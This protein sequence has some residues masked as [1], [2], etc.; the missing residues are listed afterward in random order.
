MPTPHAP[1]LVT[2]YVY[3]LKLK[4]V[5]TKTIREVGWDY[6][7]TDPT[8]QQELG[9]HHFQSEV[10]MAKGA[11]TTAVHSSPSPPTRVVTQSAL[12]KNARNPFTERILITC[13]RYDGGSVWIADPSKGKD[14]QTLGVPRH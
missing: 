8:T 2:E 6:I 11:Q 3:T 10:K 1:I 9:R 12:K 5:G 14:C 13:L 4:N 7:F